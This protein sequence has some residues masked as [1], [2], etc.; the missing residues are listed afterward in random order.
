MN[1]EEQLELTGKIVTSHGNGM[2]TVQ[3]HVNN[4]KILGFISGKIRM[5]LIRILEGDEVMVKLSP[6]DLTK[7]RI[8]YR[9]PRKK[10]NLS[11]E[12]NNLSNQN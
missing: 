11:S 2:F 5:K 6:Y 12:N 3:L 8:T 1:K 9:F 10:E 4:I 7:G